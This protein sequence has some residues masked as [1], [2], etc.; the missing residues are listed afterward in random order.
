MSKIEA[1]ADI[2][3][4]PKGLF[5]DGNWSGLAESATLTVTDP[6]SGETIAEVAAGSVSDVDLAVLAARRTF[7]RGAWT[8]L[9][10][11]ERGRLL[12]R[13]ADMIDAQVEAIARVEVRDNGMPLAAAR[14]LARL[15]AETFRYFA[16][17][18]TRISGETADVDRPGRML[19]AYTLREPLGVAA[20]I[21]PWNTPFSSACSKLAPALAAGCSAILK[22]AEETP[23]T[24]LMLGAI[25]ERAGI[26]AGVVNIVNGLGRVAGAA[27]ASHPAVDKIAF[28]GSTSVGREI[29]HAAAGNLK[30]VSLELGGKS[31][32]I[33][34]ADADI[35][36]AVAGLAVGAF[37]NSGQACIAG[38]KILVHRSVYD[39]V[40][41]R[42]SKHSRDL[43]LGD[44]FDDQAQLGPL[45]S[46][47]QLNRVL[48]LVESGR[49]EGADILSGGRRHDR[50]GFFMQP[51]VMTAP[52]AGARI[53][54]EEI[55]GPVATLLPFDE[56]DEAV[57]IA[58]DT[59]YGLAAA[60]WTRDIGNAHRMARRLRAG[61]VWLNCQMVTDRR[62]PFGGYKQSGWGRESGAEGLDAYLQTKSVFAA[63]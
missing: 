12:W 21:I 36:D 38:S 57:T 58:N 55:F 47:R 50:Q 15:G 11:F 48:E 17:W 31:P 13:V 32:T 3:A 4:A 10:G 30:K 53:L 16:G 25:I 43:R 34:L 24:A 18:C 45:I 60:V 49:K 62:L 19:H 22:P 14:Q 33:V 28:T 63:L 37:M 9:G 41:E 5:L 35:N 29:V 40:A 27:L 59:E 54:R 56:L 26:P 8:G 39:E 52:V 20:L 23:L 1:D 2:Q 7:D 51:T 42:L 46:E 61:T 44:G 6:S